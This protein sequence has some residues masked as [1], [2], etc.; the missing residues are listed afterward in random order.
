M[1]TKCVSFG[2]YW[3]RAIYK[4]RLMLRAFM[5]ATPVGLCTGGRCVP[6][7]RGQTCIFSCRHPACIRKQL[8]EMSR[9]RH[10][11]F[12]ARP[13]D[14]RGRAEGRRTGRG[15]CSGEGRGQPVV[16]AGGG[17]REA[18]DAD[19]RQAHRRADFRDQGLDQPG[20][21]VG[22]RRPMRKQPQVS[23]DRG[24]ADLAGGAELLGVSEAGAAPVAGGFGAGESDR[25]LPGKDA[26]GQGS[27]GCAAGRS[28]HSAATRL[29]GPDRAAADAGR[30]CRLPG[31]QRLRM[32]GST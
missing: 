28:N 12:Q 32:H 17:A 21:A 20:C 1:I 2:L 23:F 5:T 30:D 31:R 10:S 22:R 27:H 11:T 29:H 16:P 6:F 26:P 24:D 15:D 25:S 7:R 13:A 14:S 19:G 4:C 9:R 3:L 8:L 18:V